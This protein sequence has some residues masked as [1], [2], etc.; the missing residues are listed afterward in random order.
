MVCYAKTYFNVAIWHGWKLWTW[1]LTTKT[2]RKGYRSHS[3]RCRQAEWRPWLLFICH[4]VPPKLYSHFDYAMF[5]KKIVAKPKFHTETH[6]L[7]AKFTSCTKNGF[8]MK[9]HLSRRYLYDKIN[10][11]AEQ[12]TLKTEHF[13]TANFLCIFSFLFYPLWIILIHFCFKNPFLYNDFSLFQ[14]CVC[15]A[16]GS[17]CQRRPNYVHWHTRH[18]FR[19]HESHVEKSDQAMTSSTSTSLSMKSFGFREEKKMRN[20]STLT[21]KRT[22]K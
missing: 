12:A 8:P 1:P 19:K 15:P 20:F 13:V 18:R 11:A 10:S 5:A 6:S 14:I 16:A 3:S 17:S 7:K 22:K 4:S 21:F 9:I 2:S